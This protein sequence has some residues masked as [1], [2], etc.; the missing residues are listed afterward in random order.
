M[1][2]PIRRASMYWVALLTEGVGRNTTEVPTVRPVV[3][4]PS[5]RRAW[6]EMM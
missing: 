1:L 4:S 3:M 2:A 5:S 6:V